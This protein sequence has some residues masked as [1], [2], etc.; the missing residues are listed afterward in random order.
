MLK[1][2]IAFGL[3]TLGFINRVLSYPYSLDDIFS[4]IMKIQINVPYK[5]VDYVYIHDW[6]CFFVEPNV[7]K[8]IVPRILRG[9]FVFVDHYILTTLTRRLCV[10]KH[11]LQ[12]I[13]SNYEKAKLLREMKVTCP[14]RKRGHIHQAPCQTS[15]FLSNYGLFVCSSI[16]W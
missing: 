13:K 11:L 4:I 14:F 7:Y 3:G 2:H 10:H 16:T 6:T 5:C 8:L 9:K 15:N 1:R 12:K